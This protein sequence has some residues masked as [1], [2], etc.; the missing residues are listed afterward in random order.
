VSDK[1]RAGPRLR[2]LH[3]TRFLANVQSQNAILFRRLHWR[4]IREFDLHGRPHQH[5]EAELAFYPPFSQPE[6]GFLALRKA[7]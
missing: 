2:Q 7:A 4:V 3:C 5:M 6:S 1:G